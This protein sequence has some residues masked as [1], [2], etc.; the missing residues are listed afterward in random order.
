MGLKILKDKDGKPRDTWYAR[1]T[2]NGTKVNVNLRVPIRGTVPTATDASGRT[3][4]DVN[5]TGDAAFEKSRKA[6]LA[7]LRDM[8]AAAKR[9]GDT[10]AVKQ[11]K[12]ADLARRYYRAREGKSIEAAEIR[13][14]ELP[15]LWRGLPRTY[16]PTA[17]RMD[18]HDL[19]FRRFAAFAS[20]YAADHGGKCDTVNTITPE[21]ARAFFDEIR[22][23]YAWETV[24]G[25][26]SLLSGAF[27]RWATNGEPNPFRAVIKRN[28]EIGAAKV[29]KRP[30]SEAELE[31]LFDAA[32]DDD[33]LR[34]LIDCAAC[35]GA[36]IG[37]V[38]RLTWDCVDLRGGFI[39]VLTAK[40][41][42]HVTIPIFPRLKATLERLAA[43]ADGFGTAFVFPRAAAMYNH[44]NEKGQPDQRVGIFRAVKPLIALAVYGD[45]PEAEIGKVAGDA[46]AEPK[47]P[48]QICAMIEG[49]RFAP[50]KKARVIDTYRRFA[51]GETYAQITAATGRGKAI[52][53]QDLEAVEDLTGERVRP[54]DSAPGGRAVMSKR[55]LVKRTR[56]ARGVGKF[57]ASLY[58]W[59]SLRTSFVTLALQYGVPIEDVRKIVGHTT[60]RMTED[61]NRANKQ[62]AAERV[63]R[64]MAGSVFDVPKPAIGETIEADTAAVAPVT[65]KPSVE[66]FIEGLTDD[67]RKELA[68][69][70]L[71]L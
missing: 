34:P 64:Q 37:D 51:A 55:E 52:I 12:T 19:V 11:A 13:L 16:T 31:R 53:S 57:A 29:N 10:R 65:A 17:A 54:G 27:T 50:G 2:R 61:Y 66:A 38:C 40:A 8:E 60:K 18:Y 42:V 4:F 56:A 1:F 67:Q 47:T 48:D 39:D 63:K 58:G 30:L 24:K 45:K 44:V 70:L 25:Q 15:A 22:T 21:I 41:G 26:M 43:D 71:G 3:V 46:E 23:Q 20:S 9:T 32:A 33:F 14:D 49:S 28:R 6:A 36:R 35:T 68:R 59:H 62:H 7:A 5:G 69:K